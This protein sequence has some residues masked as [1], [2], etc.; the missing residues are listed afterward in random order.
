L[1]DSLA[2]GE[3]PNENIFSRTNYRQAAMEKQSSLAM[4]QTEQGHPD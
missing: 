4:G 2:Q 3:G 1:H